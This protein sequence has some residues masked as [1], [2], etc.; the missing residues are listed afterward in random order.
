M[1]L[2]LKDRVKETTTTTSTGTYTL[3][4]AVVGYQSFSVVG[5]G[6]TTYY[7]V[8]DNIDWEV[9]IGTYTASGTTLSRDTILES[10]NGGSAVNWGPGSKDVFC[11]YPAERSMYVDGTT[12]TPAIAAR[13]GFAN[14]AQGSALSIL[15]VT[16]NA[17]ADNASIAAGTD[18]QVLRRSGTSVAFG[19][20]NLA[21]SAAVT[22][23]L[24]LANG[25]TGANLTDPNADRILFWDDSAGSVAFLEAGTG[26]TISG[27]TI[28]A[29][30]GVSTGQSIVY[31]MVFGG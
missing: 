20:V 18:H 22:G 12:I 25:G 24:S 19:S 17:T 30:G 27:T 31:S 29:S 16:G 26:L 15:G 6:N 5:D 21:Q 28:S 11:T 23:Q 4:G 10:S 2:V 13:L 3:S 1:A 7:A 8:T 14:L 9:G